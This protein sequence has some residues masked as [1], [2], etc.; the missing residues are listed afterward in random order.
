MKQNLKVNN[1]IFGIL[2]V[3]IGILLVA[4]PVTCIKAIVI[5]L[6]FGA[7]ADGIYNLIQNQSLIES[8][9]FR[10]T[11]LTKSISSI[12]VGVLA[13]VLPLAF[14]RNCLDCYGLC[15]SCVFSCVCYYGIL[16][17]ISN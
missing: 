6:G 14:A 3:V 2:A 5:I 15:S 7:I 8:K 17:C 13:I 12:L 9:T 1:I 11:I 10:I 16:R 4:I